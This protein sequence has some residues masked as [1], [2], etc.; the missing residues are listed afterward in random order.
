MLDYHFF[1]PSKKKKKKKKKKRKKKRDKL[2]EVNL[3]SILS[4]RKVVLYG[5]LAKKLPSIWLMIFNT[6]W[7]SD[8]L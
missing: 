7:N 6:M 4:L 5:N 3:D 1:N 8:Q 2:S